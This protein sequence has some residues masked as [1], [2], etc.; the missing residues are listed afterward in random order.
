[1]W[2]RNR[3]DM[4]LVVTMAL[5]PNTSIQR[6]PSGKKSFENIEAKGENADT[7][8]NRNFSMRAKM[9]LLSANAL[10]LDKAKTFCMVKG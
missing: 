5:N 4:T 2:V 3:H 10:N 8:S 1:M 7:L 9:K 6:W